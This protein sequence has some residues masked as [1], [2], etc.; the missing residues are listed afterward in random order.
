M[1]DPHQPR[2]IDLSVLLQI[3][4][5]ALL[6]TSFGISFHNMLLGVGVGV[7]FLILVLLVGRTGRQR[8]K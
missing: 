8:S 6:G 4:S 7:V 3:A 2:K 5:A 1:T